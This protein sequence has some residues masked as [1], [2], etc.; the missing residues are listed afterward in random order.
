MAAV[1][2]SL[3]QNAASII[4]QQMAAPKSDTVADDVQLF[5]GAALGFASIHGA[6]NTAT[7]SGNDVVLSY[8][9]GNVSTISN[10]VVDAAGKAVASGFTYTVPGMFD[11]HM[12]GSFSYNYNLLGGA[13][14]LLNSDANL[15]DAS[16]K[17]SY[18][19]SDAHYDP[20]LGNATLGIQGRVHSA[21]G[22]D[23]SGVINTI[24]GKG[25]KFL[26]S[27]DATGTLNV[28]GNGLKV[29]LLQAS[30]TV[31]GVLNGYHEH[32]D[33]GGSIT[34]DNANIPVTSTTS[35]DLGLALNGAN[36]AGDDVFTVTLPSNLSTPWTINAGDGNDQ[37]ILNGG[38]SLLSANGG[39]GNDTIVLNSH[40]HNVNGGAGVDTVQLNETRSSVT[41]TAT[42]NGYQLTT[43]NGATDQLTNVE[44]LHFSD[45]SLALDTAGN[46]GQAYRLYQAA[47]DRTPDSVGLGYWIAAMDNGVSLRSVADSFVKSAEFTAL[48][49]SAP[50]NSDL[51]T[52]F[53]Q[54]VLHR[55]GDAGGFA[56]WLDKLDSHVATVSDVLMSFSE[57]PENQAALAPVIGT[58][59]SYTPWG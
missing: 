46:A 54:N 27:M 6:N 10:P 48:Y 51:L 55:A 40:G 11:L 7:H 42:A 31:S 58:S 28:S 53:Y 15:T 57:S 29:G 34:I 50:S 22:G 4:A 35:I 30:P 16:F 45:G 33:D 56:Y 59:I 9:D 38:N 25:E 18:A 19:S 8:A 1:N 37:I 12:G 44:R 32:Y 23:F 24:T 26:T 47:F 13:L 3:S 36:F 39:N 2:I 41:I 49:G 14:S 52:G 5:F 20:T 43:A 17:T 21:A